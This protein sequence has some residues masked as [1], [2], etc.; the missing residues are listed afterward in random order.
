MISNCG[1]DENGKYSGGAAGDQT[2]AEWE[3]REQ[4]EVLISE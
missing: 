3:I 2:G 1:Y 4:V